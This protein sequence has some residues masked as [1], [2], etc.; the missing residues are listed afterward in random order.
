LPLADFSLIELPL[1][2]ARRVVT[3][4]E[5]RDSRGARLRVASV[6]LITTP[7]PWRVLTT[8]NSSR[9]RQALGLVEALR[10]LET[11]STASTIVAGDFNT[12]SVRESALRHLRRHFPDSPDPLD[13]PTRGPFPTDHVFFRRGA[14][15][16]PGGDRLVA[17]SYRRAESR[18]YSDHHPVIVTF[19][20]DP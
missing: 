16:P 5:V 15:R 14:D 9:L 19:A 6:H 10:R 8:G 11:G 13:R 18:Y 1:E 2:S 20:F 7:P 17:G 4:A 3:V 12:W